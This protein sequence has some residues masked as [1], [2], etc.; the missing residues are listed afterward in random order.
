MTKFYDVETL[1][2]DEVRP[3]PD[4][5][6]MHNENQL[7]HIMESI[8]SNGYYR[9]IV[10]SSDNYILAGHGVYEACRKLGI[11]K[12][13]VVKLPF[14]H[15]EKQ[16]LKVLTGDNEIAKIADVDDRKLTELLK[17]IMDETSSLLGTGFDEKQLAN[18]VYVT[19]HASEIE[20]FDAAKEWVGMPQYD[21][22]D[23][24]DEEAN[25]YHLVITFTSEENRD[26][27]LSKFPIKVGTRIGKKWST[28]WPYQ[29][30]A[31]RKN[32]RIDSNE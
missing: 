15:N 6:R 24:F 10:I 19:R 28:T 2:L 5:Y 27:F 14:Q 25:S 11:E 29:D 8:K 20:D 22:K 21:W 32:L 16:A 1:M 4:N 17:S 9:N 30:R 23:P 7:E 3:H 31:D 18:L 12:I 26:D 13:K